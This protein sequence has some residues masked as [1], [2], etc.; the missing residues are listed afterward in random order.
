MRF[1]ER[2]TVLC[3]QALAANDEIEVR[4]IL[5]E[6]RLALHQHIEQL[7]GGLLVAY[8]ES[9]IFLKPSELIQRRYEARIGI[10]EPEGSAKSQDAGKDVSRTWQQVVHEI[11]CERNHDRALQLSQELSRFFPQS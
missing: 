4:E 9:M 6:L 2:V 7:R 10:M 8:T 5:T 11:A 3:A 1:E